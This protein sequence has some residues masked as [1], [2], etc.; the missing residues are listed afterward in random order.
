MP[1]RINGVGEFGDF[2]EL[3][4]ELEFDHAVDTIGRIRRVLGKGTAFDKQVVFFI[5]QKPN[6]EILEMTKQ[7]SENG[8]IVVLYVVTEGKIDDFCAMSNA[9]RRIIAVTPQDKLEEIL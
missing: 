7:I 8:V 9:N 4:K 6:L 3:I 5:V 1:R 2:Y